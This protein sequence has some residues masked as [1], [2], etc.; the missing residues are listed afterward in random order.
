MQ[1]NTSTAGNDQGL[2][3][4]DLIV[5]LVSKWRWFALSIAVCVGI[6]WFNYA[7]SPFVYYRSAT[8]I[9]KDPSNKT[10]TTGL[11][12]FDNIINKVNVANEIL[13][14]RSKK[15][16]REV[17]Q[18]LHADV[19][20]QVEEGLRLN[21]L[22]TQSPVLL[23][24]PDALPE[25]RFSLTVTPK[26]KNTVELSECSGIG[27]GTSRT[28]SL[29][30]TVEI[31]KGMR[32][33][34]TPTNYYGASWQNIPIRV[35]KFSL[36]SMVNYY[37]GA[38]GI[39][40]EEEE[41]S[42]LTLALKDNSAARAEDVLNTLIFVYNE[43]AIR[44]KNQV[45]INTADFI[46][47]RLIIIESELGSVESDLE[48]F[49]QRNQIVDIASSAGMY[50][51]ESQKYSIDALELET[52]LRLA[53]F[54]KDYLTDPTKDTDL[55][56]S[57]TGIGDMNIES[58]ISLYNTAKLKRDA[59]VDDSS[60]N[61]PVVQ[62][63]NNSLRAMKQNIIR[64]VDNMIV[65]LNVKRNDAQSRELQAQ[66]R[67]TSIPTKER[68]MLSIERQQKIKETLYLY[69]LN[70]R[71]E[72]ALS[73]A[74]ADN[75]ARVI[76][77]AEG[78]T[79][80]ISPNR[81]RI[82]L[83]GL[84]VGLA[85][86]GVSCLTVLFMDTRVRS[87]KEVEKALS[88]PFLGEIPLDREAGKRRKRGDAD[89]DKTDEDGIVAEAF[90]VLRTNMAFMSRKDR[91][92]QVIT[93][94]SFNEGAGKTF[95]AS[96]LAMSFV[97]AKKRVVLVDLDIRK[98]TL[99]RHFGICRTGVTNYLAD[100]SVTV[101]EIIQHREHFDVIS[102]GATAP[103]PAEL[104]MDSRL[105]ELFDAL[106]SRYDLIIADNV[107]VGIIAD[108]SIANRI[109]DLTI[110]V[111]R[112]GRLDRRQLPDIEAMYEGRKL[113]NMAL[114]LNGVDPTRTGYGYGRYGY[115]YGYGKKS[116]KNDPA[117]A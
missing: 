29:N 31:S 41:S 95:I 23:S 8:V 91:P 80:P 30:D 111:I 22:Y 84:I 76:D 60:E 100:P 104:L 13:Q 35:R 48:S 39:Q 24:F 67:V 50:M 79:Q 61:N 42:I 25:Q 66:D 36:E 112:A 69:L 96:N 83:L 16:M 47:E 78:S 45:A 98:G 4:M 37:R 32:V 65:T 73:Q 58:Q 93:F 92:S 17:V 85:I 11:D 106:R 113:K 77:G 43:E 97:Y 9:I 46:N 38:L 40:Q 55:I 110:F 115:G 49:K 6:A 28:V 103:N 5:Y 12:R 19:S 71:E 20:Y 2:N 89:T 3:L 51:T 33:V 10:S 54:I 62:E 90:R 82:L 57:N 14:F 59:L 21:E 26:D 108:A 18:R 34:A 70:K 88:V 74:M 114:V 44:D 109:A 94:T 116:K 87:R 117:N 64:A 72:N 15:L 63:L 86:P 75:N 1:T 102:F 68:Q 101:D 105:D 99:S 7:R 81:N 52:Q 53:Q 56:P 107:P 27:D